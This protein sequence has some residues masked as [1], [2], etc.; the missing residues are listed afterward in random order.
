MTNIPSFLSAQNTIE[1]YKRE[2]LRPRIASAVRLN[3]ECC[4]IGAHI[5]IPEEAGAF[6][7]DWVAEKWNVSSTDLLDWAIG[8]DNGFI[9]QNTSQPNGRFAGNPWFEA[10]QIVGRACGIEFGK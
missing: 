2:G 6:D 8:F 4:G 1:A 5:D 3:G 7:I 10:G 9:Y